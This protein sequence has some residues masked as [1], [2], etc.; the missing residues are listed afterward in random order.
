LAQEAGV[1]RVVL[2][3]RGRASPKRQEQER[4]AWFRRGYRFRAGIEG[5]ISVLRRC[6]GLDR[7]RDHG[8]AGMG[9]WV[10][11]GILTANLAT[12]AR[13]VAARSAR[14]AARAA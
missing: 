3:D 9:R 5:R 6:F 4:Q 14:Q 10:G 7:C 12:I 13:T 1:K 2:P 11:W 8:E